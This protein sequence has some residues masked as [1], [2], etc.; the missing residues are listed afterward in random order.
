MKVARRVTH[1]ALSHSIDLRISEINGKPHGVQGTL[2]ASLRCVF[3][4]TD[5]PIT[6]ETIQGVLG[7]LLTIQEN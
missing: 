5:E 3:F 4:N 2:A 6:N 1:Y 7:E